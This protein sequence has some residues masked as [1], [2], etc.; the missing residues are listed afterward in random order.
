VPCRSSARS[1]SATRLRGIF[2]IAFGQLFSVEGADDVRFV[3][4][5]EVDETYLGPKAYNMHARDRKRAALKGTKGKIAVIGAIE[6]GG[7]VRARVIPTTDTETLDRFVR[8]AVSQNVKLIAT[9]EHSGYRLLGKDFNHGVVTHTKGEYVV[10]A[11]HTNTI[12]SF[13]SLLKRGI[14]GSYHKVSKEHLPAYVAE[15]EFR[16]NNRKNPHLFRDTLKRLLSTEPLPFE[17]LIT[18]KSAA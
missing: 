4:E 10:G 13:W 17:K 2:A 12:E 9:D 15:F 3:G 5:V 18:K 11:I 6:R 14:V 16:F 8:E 7:R 1:A